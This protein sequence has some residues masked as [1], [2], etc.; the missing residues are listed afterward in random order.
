MRDYWPIGFNFLKIETNL[1]EYFVPQ[2]HIEFIYN[3]LGLDFLENETFI[4]ENNIKLYENDKSRN[5]CL[6]QFGGLDYKKRLDLFYPGDF[7]KN[8][9]SAYDYHN[10]IWKRYIGLK[11]EA[12]SVPFE[13]K[14]ILTIIRFLHH[15]LQ[16][17]KFKP[18]K[19]NKNSF[20][21]NIVK[22]K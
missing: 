14:N 6:S 12:I 20:G 1:G 15:S 7:P 4:Y 18:D 3:G 16:D 10:K 9:E 2:E 19:D 11:F 13:G 21:K 17:V 8:L 22:I 5:N